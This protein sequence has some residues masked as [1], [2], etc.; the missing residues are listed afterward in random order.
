MAASLAR[1]PPH[2]LDV[3]HDAVEHHLHNHEEGT[4][5]PEHPL[6]PPLG[7]SNQAERFIDSEV[8][9]SNNNHEF[10]DE[11]GEAAPTE[12]AQEA[13]RRAESPEQDDEPPSPLISREQAKHRPR[14]SSLS[15]IR[16]PP[17][18]TPSGRT[19]PPRSIS[20]SYSLSQAGGFDMSMYRKDSSEPRWSSG[21]EGDEGPDRPSDFRT[22]NPFRDVMQYQD[23]HQRER[24]RHR[25]EKMAK[26]RDSVGGYD[27]WTAMKKR[28]DTPREEFSHLQWI[29]EP[30][31]E[32]KEKQEKRSD[33]KEKG[34][35]RADGGMQNAQGERKMGSPSAGSEPSH[36]P[37]SPPRI[38][39]PH[40]QSMPHIQRSQSDQLP[41]PNATPKWTRLRSLIPQ[42]AAQYKIHQPP[43]ASAVV[44]QSVNITDELIAGGLSA[45]VLRL[46][47]ER[48]E[49]DHR[50]VPILFHRLRIRVSDSLHPLHGNK[51]VFR[52]ECEYANG[53][54]RWVVYR[55]LRE[56]LSLHAHYAVSNAYFRN[57]GTLPDFPMMSML[58]A[59]PVFSECVADST[60][61]LA[62]PQVPQR[63]QQR[64]Q[65]SRLCTYATR[66][67][68]ELSHRPHPCG[69]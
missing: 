1:P 11:P 35:E 30:G 64:R 43:Q 59:L 15:G 20:R 53:A 65:S 58:N 62:V 21:Q 55:Q 46:W 31:E 47:F 34:K 44:P 37:G 63:A 49:R 61:R 39:P 28:L 4:S 10:T 12:T 29:V 24:E 25:A 6:T 66:S 36:P 17:P 69:G 16:R 22:T 38:A 19:G 67:T 3:V 13:F 42:I 68:R 50:R 57:V 2:F 9:R 14:R 48:D 32:G 8:T 27:L 41:Q 54:V 5:P 26:R 52:I 51:A 18:N 56:F 40:S 23:P 60:Y 33:E 7:K 45:L